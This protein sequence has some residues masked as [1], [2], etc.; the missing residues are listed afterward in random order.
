MAE[1]TKEAKSLTA[2]VNAHKATLALAT[3][4]LVFSAGLLKENIKFTCS[5]KWLL[6]I[7]WCFLGVSIIAGLLVHLR[8]PIMIA[9]DKQDIHDRL[10]GIPGQ[11]HHIAFV[12]GVVLLG[13]AMIVILAAK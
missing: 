5:S 4:T 10:F 9:E 11:I 8:V 1:E 3:G 6:G 13:I 7:S 12:L 2:A